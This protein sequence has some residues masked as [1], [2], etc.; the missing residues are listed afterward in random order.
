MSQANLRAI[1][2]AFVNR[3]EACDFK[4]KRRDTLALEYF[5]GAAAAYHAANMTAEFDHVTRVCAFLICTRGYDYV[6]ELA[7]APQT[8]G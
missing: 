8:N 7:Q 6:Q 5:L 3:S 2:Q 1:A 4:G